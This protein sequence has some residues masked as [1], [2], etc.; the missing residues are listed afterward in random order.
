MSWRVDVTTRGEGP[1]Q[2]MGDVK[3][4][5]MMAALGAPC[6]VMAALGAPCLDTRCTMS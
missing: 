4:R 1:R 6:L 5:E 3:T 2:D